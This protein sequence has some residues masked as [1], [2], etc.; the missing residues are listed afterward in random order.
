M[1]GRTAARRLLLLRASLRAGLRRGL[2]EEGEEGRMWG[3]RGRCGEGTAGLSSLGCGSVCESGIVGV[4]FASR[5]GGRWRMLN[6]WA[7]RVKRNGRKRH[8]FMQC[9]T[10][11]EIDFSE[12][13]GQRAPLFISFMLCAAKA[14]SKKQNKTKQ[15]MCKR[16][17]HLRRK[18]VSLF[19]LFSR[20]LSFLLVLHISSDLP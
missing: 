8:Q 18:S 5:D 14:K 11:V 3:R 16:A 6:G 2:W 10:I 13:G 19:F 17:P 7:G 20:F 4:L 12:S 9:I 15:H 1:D